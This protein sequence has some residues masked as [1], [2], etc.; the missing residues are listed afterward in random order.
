MRRVCYKWK[1]RE[2]SEGLKAKGLEQS[3]SDV[4]LAQLTGLSRQTISK[5]KSDIKAYLQSAPPPSAFDVERVNK[6][7]IER[8]VDI[9]LTSGIGKRHYAQVLGAVYALYWGTTQI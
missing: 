6:Q 3:T 8:Y 9:A 1:A 4:E 2:S 7:S 5:S